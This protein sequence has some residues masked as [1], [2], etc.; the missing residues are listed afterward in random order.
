MESLSAQLIRPIYNRKQEKSHVIYIHWK[1]TIQDTDGWQEETH[2]PFPLSSAEE[3]FYFP[4]T[5][6]MQCASGSFLCGIHEFARE[7]GSPSL[8]C[9]FMVKDEAFSIHGNSQ[10]HMSHK[11]HNCLT[12]WHSQKKSSL[13]NVSYLMPVTL[14]SNKLCFFLN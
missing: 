7:I 3:L 5:T 8:C 14:N 6:L 13:Q 9:S 4:P 1:W 12:E 10:N 2:L 11:V